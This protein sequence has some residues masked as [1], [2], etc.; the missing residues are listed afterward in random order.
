[1]GTQEP[2]R[3]GL[4]AE[5]IARNAS[6][7]A[8]NEAPV[9]VTRLIVSPWQREIRVDYVRHVIFI[10]I[11]GYDGVSTYVTADLYEQIETSSLAVKRLHF[12]DHQLFDH[13]GFPDDDAL[14]ATVE[15]WANEWIEPD[16]STEVVP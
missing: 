5:I 10:C 2:A 16:E 7:G 4:A 15:D 11:A 6:T 8:T 14:I 1:M 9:S 3:S 13:L 12:L